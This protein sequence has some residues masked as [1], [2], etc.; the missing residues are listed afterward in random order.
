MDSDVQPSVRTLASNLSGWCKRNI[1]GIR[2]N[3]VRWL[4]SLRIKRRVRRPS[5]YSAVSAAGIIAGATAAGLWLNS[6]AA[7]L[8]ALIVLFLLASI[9]R[10]LQRIADVL[11][12]QP[13]AALQPS[14]PASKTKT[15]NERSFYISSKAMERLRPWVEDQS[16]L[17][18]ESAK[19]YCSVL[20]DTLAMVDPRLAGKAHAG[21]IWS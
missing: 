7:G 12:M 11:R 15:S 14:W 8:F 18:E 3:T 16:T 10:W 1:A 21:D 17:T 6:S 5:V 20:L 4:K 9:G 2:Q 19:A 13:S